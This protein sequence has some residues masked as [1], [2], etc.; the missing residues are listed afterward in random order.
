MAH[1]AS[2]RSLQINHVNQLD[3]AFKDW[4]VIVV[5]KKVLYYVWSSK[6]TFFIK[7][8]CLGTFTSTHSQHRKLILEFAGYKLNKC[9]TVS[10]PLKFGVGR[11]VLYLYNSVSFISNN[12]FCLYAVINMI[13][14]PR[15]LST[16]LSCSSARSRSSKNCFL[17]SLTS[18]IFTKILPD[19]SRSFSY[20]NAL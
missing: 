4:M 5:C 10:L 3:V 18:S 14:R 9:V 19:W 17:F 6:A 11:K 8:E 20:S 7:P 1:E 2:K 15:Y 13:P 16:I 12:T